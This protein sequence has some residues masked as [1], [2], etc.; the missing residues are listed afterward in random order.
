MN[1]AFI[2]PPD[3]FLFLW[4]ITS[5]VITYFVYKFLLK[6]LIIRLGINTT[7]VQITI[8]FLLSVFIAFFVVSFFLKLIQ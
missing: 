3:F 8:A 4:G 7:K 2:I 1:L 5:V 6:K